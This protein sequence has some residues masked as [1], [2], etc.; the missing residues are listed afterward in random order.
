[1]REIVTPPRALGLFA[2]L[3][4]IA[5]VVGAWLSWLH[6][7]IELAFE[8]V[9]PATRGLLDDAAP[10][11]ARYDASADK[12]QLLGPCFDDQRQPMVVGG[13][14]LVLRVSARD[15][16]PYASALRPPRLFIA[17]VSRAADPVILDAEHFRLHGSVAVRGTVT[18]NTRALVEITGHICP[19]P[20]AGPCQS[21]EKPKLGMPGP[22]RSFAA[23]YSAAANPNSN[24]FSPIPCVQVAGR[25]YVD[26]APPS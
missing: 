9:G 3:I 21:S 15:G 14:T 2:A 8:S 1:M 4:A 24:A 12:L 18:Q 5:V 23:A 19:P 11:R 16:L 13:E 10:Q 22:T 6:A 25:W 20:S 7:P 26:A 17:S